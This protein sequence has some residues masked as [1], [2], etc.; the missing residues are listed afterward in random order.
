MCPTIH[1]L[2]WILSFDFNLWAPS[3]NSV[4]TETEG[5]PRYKYEPFYNFKSKINCQGFKR[6]EISIPMKHTYIKLFFRDNILKGTLS[7]QN[8]FFN[9]KIDLHWILTLYY[10]HFFF[11]SQINGGQ[12]L[13][14]F[15]L[16]P[17]CTFK[18]FFFVCIP[19]KYPC[20]EF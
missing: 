1:C 3:F 7:K 20:N 13:I 14:S 6:K 2:L 11:Q 12:A 8:H 4:I 18:I 5:V 9:V 19:I 10:H 17:I 15:D 16:N